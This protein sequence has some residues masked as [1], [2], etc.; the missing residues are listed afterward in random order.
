MKSL[1]TVEIEDFLLN[2]RAPGRYANNELNCLAKS[3]TKKTLNFAL[4]FPDKYEIG[5]SHLGLKI[6]YSILNST[7][8]FTADRVYTP[9]V[10]L[11]EFLKKEDIPLFS[12][13]NRIALYEFDVIGFTL[14]YELSN[15]NI[16][17]ML[18]LSKIPLLSKNRGEHDPLIIAGGPCAFNPQPLAMFIDAFVIGDGEDIIIE[19]AESL[20][21]NKT[22]SRKE[23]LNKLS[24]LRGIYIPEFYEEKHDSNGTYVIPKSADYPAKIKKNYFTD[25]DNKAKIH[26]PHLVPLTDIVHNRPAIEIMRGCTRGCRFCQAGM[27]YRPVRERDDNLLVDIIKEEIKLNGWDEISL[28]SLSTSDYSAIQPLIA[29]LNPILKATHTKLSLPSLRL[30]TIE[31]DFVQAIK[32]MIGST[33]TIAPEAGSERLR[34]VI[35]KQI[36][37][38]EIINS[39]EFALKIGIRSVKLYFMLGLPTE[40]ED[41]IQSIINLVGKIKRLKNYLRIKISLSTFIPK[42]FTPF[43]WSPLDSKKN[44]IAKVSRIKRGLSKYH[45]VKVSYNSY[46]QS[47]LESVISRGDSKIGK[48]I[49]GAFERGAMFD[50]W[51]ENF[52]FALWEEAAQDNGIDLQNYSDAIKNGKKMCWS[53]IDSGIREDF[54]VSEYEKAINSQTTPDCRVGKCS[55]CGVCTDVQNRFLFPEKQK[56]KL[57]FTEKINVEKI[58]QTTFFKYRVFYEK[59]RKMRFS[60]HRDLMKIIYQ[61]VRKSGLPVYHTM[62]F[63]RRPKISLCPALL[64]GMTGKNEFFDIR[65][66]KLM[67]ENIVLEQMQINLPEDL[68]IHKVE[69]IFVSTKNMGNFQNERL[70]LS[71]KHNFNWDEK[72]AEYE[73]TSHF[74]NK[75]GKKVLTKDSIHSVISNGDGLIVEKNILGIRTSDFLQSILKITPEDVSKL[76]ITRLKM[77]K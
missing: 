60:S 49:L 41:D 38:E 1:K 72:I 35:N 3:I 14:Q 13:E 9:D 25:F 33:L 31:K 63:N 48:L 15:S 40:T 10:D 4:A 39:I 57:G 66:I 71:S 45:S 26:F 16:L 42:P 51:N 59:G 70:L 27:I 23:R 58:Q 37:E 46:E 77:M 64:L 74:I 28:N 52:N 69:R 67:P 32:K 62:G 17:L 61:V 53:H 8:K 65:L 76:R 30:D 5:M 47:L 22:A 73:K 18:Q 21:I 56:A 54:L 19:L 2:F 11:I 12:I 6:L 7:E 43:Q 29:K 50:A 34:D 68:I 36:S 55:N 24:K 20:L 44:I 75:K